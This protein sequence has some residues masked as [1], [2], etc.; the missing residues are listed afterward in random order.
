MDRE[1]RTKGRRGELKRI[2]PRRFNP[3]RQAW[4]PVLHTTRGKRSYTALFSN[5]ARAHE[6][7]RT[8]DWVVVYADGG[9][10]E[11]QCTEMTAMWGSLKGKR[12]VRGREVE[13]ARHV[14]ERAAA[15]KTRSPVSV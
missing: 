4:L 12:V 15:R 13:C 11:R 9:G 1:Y 3:A 5:T 8:H 10:S 14:A 7:G 6:F 2:A